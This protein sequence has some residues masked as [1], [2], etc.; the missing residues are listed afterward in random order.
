[1]QFKAL[2][3]KQFNS[4]IKVIQIDNGGEYQA[5]SNFVKNQG[6]IHQFSCPYTSAQNGRAERKHGHI[7]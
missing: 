5:F 2:V 7:T 1:M 3:E 6:I 4:T